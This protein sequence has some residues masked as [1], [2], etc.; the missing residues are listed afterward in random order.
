MA[1]GDITLSSPKVV[2]TNTLQFVQAVVTPTAME[3]TLQES[4]TGI[5][6]RA[7]VTNASCVGVDYAAGVFTD[8]VPRAVAGEFT[9]L[10]GLVFKANPLT[11]LM[12]TLQADGIVTV[13]GA[14]G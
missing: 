8:N 7:L 11:V 6:H 12:S 13:A 14:V 1:A 4:A 2:T 5:L 9:K 3:I 10:L